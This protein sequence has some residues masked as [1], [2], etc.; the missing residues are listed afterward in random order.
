MWR[1]VHKRLATL[2]ELNTS[3]TLCDMEDAHAVLDL[4]DELAAKVAKHNE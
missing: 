4:E 3:W 2:H 1:I